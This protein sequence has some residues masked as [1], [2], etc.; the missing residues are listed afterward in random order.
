[1]I[2]KC[3][4]SIL[5]SAT[6]LLGCGE[7]LQERR[8]KNKMAFAQA[9]GMV[10][11]FYPGDEAQQIDWDTLALYGVAQVADCRTPEELKGTLEAIFAPVTPG[12]RFTNTSQYGPLEAITPPDTTGMTPVSWQHY[13]VDLGLWSNIY[14]S[15]RIGRQLDTEN[16][17]KLAIEELWPASDFVNSEVTVG[18]DIKND[19]PNRLAVFF[20]AAVNNPGP[21]DYV[22]F[23]AADS[24]L[25]P[26]KNNG[27]WQTYSQKIIVGREQANKLIRYGIYTEGIGRFSV[28]NI[29]LS[30]S[31][32]DNQATRFTEFFNPVVYNYTGR[33][34]A[35]DILTRDMLFDACN[36]F[37]D[38][39][40]QE[41]APGL[42]IQVPLALYGTKDVTYPECDRDRLSRLKREI[43]QVKYTD[44][45][46][47]DADLVVVWNVFNY[48]QPYLSDL[49][50]S[51]SDALSEALAQAAEFET[52]H[53]QPLRLMT[54]R[55]NDAHVTVKI[56][57]DTR[58]NSSKYLPLLAEK[59]GDK[60]VVKHSIDTMLRAG[61]IIE[62]VNGIPATTSFQAIQ[63]EISGSPQYKAARAMPLWL[64]SFG[65]KESADIRGKRAGKNFNVTVP[66]M[67]RDS[68]L[69][70]MKPHILFGRQSQWIDKNTLYLNLSNTDFDRV[71]E[72]LKNR[73]ND[74]T[75]IIDIRTGSQ[76]HFSNI[77]PLLYR[78][79]AMIPKRDGI[80]LIP[81]VIK[82][83]SPKLVDTLVDV[84]PP[85][86]DKY[87]IFLTGPLNYSHDE[88]MLDYIRYAGLGYF[89]GTSTAGCNGRLNKIPLPSGGEVSFTGTKVL[90]NL[91]KSGYYYGTGIQPDLY[92]APAVGDIGT[93]R[94]VALERAVNI[95]K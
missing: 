54:A 29:S 84:A 55:L 93:G 30:P 8:V 16:V 76:F 86:P 95:N 89:V 50:I 13:G 87:T 27:G 24:T 15:K 47:M 53:S 64:R 68:Y 81:N 90:S 44:R 71:K 74:Q 52:Y 6:L 42:Y 56:L 83:Q 51:W 65:D 78:T 92:A 58:P 22:E 12:V 23:C 67:A 26:V 40:T 32:K 34:G 21:E 45:D 5:L 7:S 60:L 9:Y 48:F 4:Y 94:D 19:T 2:R 77:L 63:A 70:V 3:L 41:L 35:Y 43:A 62:S 25:L 31:G 37:G 18:V 10:R 72:L 1:M 11:W 59:I 17:S 14:V 61:D 49:D 28:R 66:L 73:K 79:K 85:A 80:S 69:E 75:V 36:Q 57:K 38:I 46:F 39:A 20:R 82:P 33:T 88:E 91:G